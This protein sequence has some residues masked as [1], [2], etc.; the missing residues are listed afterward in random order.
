NPN[1]TSSSRCSATTDVQP[2]YCATSSTT[3][4]SPS[5]R[6]T[7]VPAS[8]AVYRP[9]AASGRSAQEPGGGTPAAS[10]PPVAGGGVAGVSRGVSAGLPSVI[11]RASC[12]GG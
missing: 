6:T 1:T 4:R 5:R 12:R 8:P 7:A 3:C 11:G 9:S 10:P 2:D